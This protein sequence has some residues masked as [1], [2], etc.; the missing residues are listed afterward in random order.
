MDEFR[1]EQVVG[2]MVTLFE[3]LGSER[4]DWLPYAYKEPM[5]NKFGHEV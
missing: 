5:P 3:R 1:F 2:F 4:K